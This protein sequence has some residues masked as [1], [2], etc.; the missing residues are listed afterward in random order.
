MTHVDLSARVA[1]AV[2]RATDYLYGRQRPDGGWTDRLSSSTI[3]TALGIL[4]LARAG[5]DGYRTQIDAGLEW[6]RQHQ[7]SDGGWSLVDADPPSDE[8]ITAF[9]VAAFEVLDPDGSRTFIESGMKFIA[10]NG[11]DAVITPDLSGD[12]PRTWREI[13]PIVWAMERL[14]DITV[15]PAQPMEIMLL[16]RRLRNR[17]SIVLPGV[18][19]LGIGQSRVVPASRLKRWAQ[20]LAEPRAL[21]W[22]RSVQAPNGGIEECPLMAALVFIGLRTAG[23]DVGPDIQR[24]CVTYLLETIRPDGS[25]PIDRDLEIAVTAYAVLALG[26]SVDVAREPRLEATRDWLLST[27]WTEPFT[28]LQLPAGGWSWASPSGWPESEDTAVVLTVL[29]DLGLSADHPAVR[30]GLR[31][32]LPMQ[33]RDGSWSEW[34]RNSEMIHD[35]PC[36]GVTSHVLMALHKYG[37]ANGSNSATERGLRYFKKVQGDDGAIPSLWFRDATHGTSKVLETY[38]ELGRLNEPVPTKAKRWLLASQRPDGAWPTDIVEG[39]PEGG[40]AEETGWA[41]Y[42]LL[43]A[44]Q[45]PSDR[46]VTQAVEWLLDAQND[47]G[48]WRQSGVGLYYDTLYYSNDLI[49]HTYTLRALARWQRCATGAS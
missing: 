18:L 5:R 43:R 17:A 7:R 44:G 4:A 40:T 1:D 28:P 19:G 15:Q 26:E 39:P 23:E 25:W 36:A 46:Q 41:L 20:R 14:H 31:W 21:S 22:L 48:T 29:A 3:A 47:S 32:L 24:G 37:A 34:V 10:A 9:A 38:A 33:N 13:V 2:A 6:L 30:S 16:P 27:Q 45:P 8:S 11:G 49:A 42:S 12:G 35:G